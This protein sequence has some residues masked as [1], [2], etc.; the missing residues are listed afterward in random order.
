MEGRGVEGGEQ[1]EERERNQTA[2]SFYTQINQCF[3]SKAMINF[4]FAFTSQTTNTT[5]QV[6]ETTDIHS[7]VDTKAK[8]S[9]MWK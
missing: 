4:Q 8:I 5:T 2:E 1:R 3:K 7:I 6:T 9:E